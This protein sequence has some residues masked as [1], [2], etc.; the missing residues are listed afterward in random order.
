MTQAIKGTIIEK[1]N[2]KNNS[3]IR[4][5][6]IT[7]KTIEVLEALKREQNE[8]RKLLGN[9]WVNSNKVICNDYGI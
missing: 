3:S 2:P 5:I 8:Q 9:K 6:K 7:I 4:T 1:P